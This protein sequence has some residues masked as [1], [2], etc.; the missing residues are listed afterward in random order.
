MKKY[1]VEL[2]AFGIYNDLEYDHEPT[3]EELDELI[4]LFI[5]GIQD[6]YFDVDINCYEE[7][8]EN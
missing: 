5:D 7:E 3:A 1:T 8:A 4:D 2:S 6:G